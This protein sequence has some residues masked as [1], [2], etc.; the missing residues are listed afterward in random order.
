V[1]Q[2]ANPVQ[3]QLAWAHFGE[4]QSKLWHSKLFEP[5]QHTAMKISPA[6]FCSP[7]GGWARGGSSANDGTV[8]AR[9]HQALASAIALDLAEW[10]IYAILAIRY[11][12]RPSRVKVLLSLGFTCG[13]W[14]FLFSH[15]QGWHEQ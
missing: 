5:A 8:S 6:C 4:C 13:F 15:H 11:N 2:I 3:R 12:P 1:D 10:A 7:G 14:G 9:P